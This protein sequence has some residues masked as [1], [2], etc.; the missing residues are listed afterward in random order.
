VTLVAVAPNKFARG[1]MGPDSDAPAVYEVQPLDAALLRRYDTDAHLVTYVVRGAT[2]Q[3]RI[4]KPGL[5]YFPGQAEVAVF[6]CD[7]D[8]PDHRPWDRALVEE[9]ERQYYEVEAFRTAGIYLTAHGRR[10]VQPIAQ[11]IPVQEVEPYL[12]RWLLELERGGLAVDWACRD[13]TRHFRLPHVRRGGVSTPSYLVLLDR[14]E[15][16]A[17]EP[18]EHAVE[19]PVTAPTTGTTAPARP[20]PVVEWSGTVPEVWRGRV[21]QMAAAVRGV[22]TEWHSLFLALAGALLARGVPPEH[23]PALCRAIS[24]AT[25]ADDRTADRETAARTTA[26][27]KLAGLRAVGYSELRRRW[28][29]VA[30]AVDAATARGAEA[31]LRVMAGAESETAPATVQTATAAM[32]QAIRRAP[33]GLTTISAE[34]GLGKTRAA[35]AVAAERA[36]KP[37]ASANAEGA[38]APLGS[39]TSISVDKHRLAQQVVDDLAALGTPAKRIFGPLSVIGPDG[40]PACRYHEVAECLV[41]GGQA[42]QWEL[43]RGR[44]DDPCEYFDECDARLGFEG[45]EDARVTVG[46][47]ALLSELDAAAGSTGLLVIDEPPDILETETI[48]QQDLVTTRKG[49]RAFEGRYAGSIEPVIVAA[50][51]WLASGE[52]AVATEL[53]HVVN[54]CAHL[55]DPL[56][57]EQ[58][59]RSSGLAAG[60]A[61]DCARA[62]PLAEGRSRKAPPI[63]SA[64]LAMAKRDV[65][66][67]RELGTASRVLRTLH[68]AL[69]S[70]TPVAVRIEGQRERVLIVTSAREEF[71]Q[72]LRRQGAVVVT[73]ANAEINVPIYAKVVGYEPAHHRFAAEDGAP[74]ERTVLRCASATRRSW[75]P[76]GQLEVASSLVAAVR[77]LFEWAGRDAATRSI[78]VI[79]MRT[80]ELA[81]RAARDPTDTSVE[82]EWK[83]A[84]Q[85]PETLQEAK[86]RLGPSVHD[87]PGQLVFGHYFAV[88]GLNTMADVDAVVTLGDPWPNLGHVKNDVAFLG[89]A[90]AWD[91][92]VEALCRAELEQAHG[93]LRVVH[94]SRPGRAL[95]IGT[96]LPGG[97]GWRSGKVQIRKLKSGPMKVAA[98]MTPDELAEHVTRLGGVR[99]AGRILQCAHTTIARYLDG[100]RAISI[101]FADLV[102]AALGPTAEVSDA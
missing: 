45:P 46:P 34:C 95:H 83:A 25:G 69:T 33:D 58:A 74:I 89:L 75:L 29:E 66:R 40:K 96:M 79:T 59:R 82:A 22:K 71:A 101:E 48:T 26:E 44:D 21:E 77:A 65:G 14:M 70:E 11:P 42:M 47:H 97:S 4:N 13:W 37:Y 61:V 64:Y 94:R 8:N 10:V 62:A 76:R 35:I 20:V 55:I 57:L 54:A 53:A 41:R 84:R 80:I 49:L 39:K 3:P 12:R 27:R 31:Q 93:R 91:A 15:P 68:Y 32:E 92:R 50:Q 24:L 17:L 7:V 6:F 28:P 102:R 99:A 85:R 9:A 2:A 51:V 38:R 63:Q 5:P 52:I 60:D 98:A 56:D 36:A 43:C 23:L 18:I 87:W 86:A 78:G 30:D 88:R 1:F 67:A 72:A 16:I 81:L 19:E 90:E 100:K 73:D